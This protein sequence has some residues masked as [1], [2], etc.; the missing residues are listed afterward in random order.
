MDL[1]G[2]LIAVVLLVFL[3]IQISKGIHDVKYRKIFQ[4]T[5]LLWQ[6]GAIFKILHWPGANM[7]L[8]IAPVAAFGVKLLSVRKQVPKLF[9]VLVL[10]WLALFGVTFSARGLRFG[11]ANDLFFNILI[12]LNGI[13]FTVLVAWIIYRNIIKNNA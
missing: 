1:I 7:I 3:L 4:G 10:V 2:W 6:L 5:L 13:L 11:S 9:D 12:V 8:I